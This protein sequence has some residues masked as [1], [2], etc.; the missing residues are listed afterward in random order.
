MYNSVNEHIAMISVRFLHRF[1][2]HGTAGHGVHSPFMYF[3][4][5]EI[6]RKAKRDGLKWRNKIALRRNERRLVLAVVHLLDYLSV[7]QI[8]L[9]DCLSERGIKFICAAGKDVELV[10]SV[11]NLNVTKPFVLI[12]DIGDLKDLRYLLQNKEYVENTTFVLLNIME[13]SKNYSEWNEIVDYKNFSLTAQ[14]NQ[15][16]WLF[17]REGVCKQHFKFRF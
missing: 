11:D 16:G 8:Y 1:K 9:T 5:R 2:A 7:K 17:C 12:A 4:C 3:F 14:T 6:L 10:K 15:F 13:N